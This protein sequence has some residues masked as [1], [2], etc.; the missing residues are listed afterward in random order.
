MWERR[1]NELL[2]IILHASATQQNLLIDEQKTNEP[3]PPYGLANIT[4]HVTQLDK[5]T[6]SVGT[7]KHNSNINTQVSPS[8]NKYTL[9]TRDTTNILIN[10]VHIYYRLYIRPPHR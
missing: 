5:H 4:K 9:H 2:G 7:G 10:K 3:N 1:G 6:D 8:L